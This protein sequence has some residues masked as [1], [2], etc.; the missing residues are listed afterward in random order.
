M[1]A[2]AHG[3]APK[4]GFR[5]VTFSSWLNPWSLICKK[6]QRGPPEHMQWPPTCFIDSEAS[7]THTLKNH[8]TLAFTAGSRVFKHLV[9]FKNWKKNVRFLCLDVFISQ[10]LQLFK[11]NFPSWLNKRVDWLVFFGSTQFSGWLVYW[12]EQHPIFEPPY[13]F[14]QI[15]YLIKWVPYVFRTPFSKFLAQTLWPIPKNLKMS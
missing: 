6:I 8:F 11:I 7:L 3:R 13:F 14:W 4:S 9:I 15:I 12:S 10:I 1:L 2:A 5:Q